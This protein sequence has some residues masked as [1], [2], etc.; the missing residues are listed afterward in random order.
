[1]ATRKP[2]RTS[3]SPQAKF[4]KTT[5]KRS[6]KV[7]EQKPPEQKPPEQKPPEQNIYE[8]DSIFLCSKVYNKLIK[9]SEAKKGWSPR[10]YMV[11]ED[12]KKIVRDMVIVKKISRSGCEEMPSVRSENLIKAYVSLTKKKLTP[13]GLVRLGNNYFSND[14]YW[15]DTSGDAIY[16]HIGYMLTVGHG[17]ICGEVFVPSFPDCVNKNENEYYSG[18]IK[19]L[20]VGLT[21]K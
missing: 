11:G 9:K 20:T 12:S 7:I 1:M 15:A 21:D 6:T 18:R 14:G 17:I 4:T 19:T 13:V 2:T 5:R 3:S 16:R 8:R 10:V